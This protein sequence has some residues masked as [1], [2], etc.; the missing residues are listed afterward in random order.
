MG[1]R[2]VRIT[3]ID[4]IGRV[5]GS[6]WHIQQD[7]KG[8]LQD[9]GSDLQGEGRLLS[10]RLR[11][12]DSRGVEDLLDLGLVPRVQG[13]LRYDLV[14]NPERYEDF[15]DLDV[16]DLLLT[17]AHADHAGRLWALD[18]EIRVHC[19]SL[20]AA[21][22]RASSLCSSGLASEATHLVE[23]APHPT[24]RGILHKP[25][26]GEVL[27]RP[28]LTVDGAPSGGLRELWKAAGSEAGLGESD[29]L[30][31][32]MPFR[33]FPVDH[34]ILGTQAFAIET[35]AGMIVHAA[36]LR[37]HGG[38]G[39]LTD[40][41]VRWLDR[42][43]V[44]ALIL[45]GTRLGREDDEP[46]TEAQC[47]E[48]LRTLVREAGRRLVVA[49]YSPRN[50]ERLASFLA[51]AQ[52]AG[53]ELVVQARTMAMLEAVGAANPAFDLLSVGGL[54][55]YDPPKASRPAWHTALRERRE[56]LVVSP[57]EIKA[58]PQKYVMEH[59][60]FSTVDL[61]D[62][63]PYGALLLDSNSGAYSSEATARYRMLG[64]WARL[65]A[66]DTAGIEFKNGKALRDPRLAPSGHCHPDDLRWLLDRAKPELL[67]PVHT[68]M[69]E[70]FREFA[71]EG[72]KVVLP[73][74]GRAIRL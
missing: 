52:G 58:K 30:A 19:S 69:P 71:P 5:G 14:L 3:P 1:S 40:A 7:E 16:R 25:R 53:R 45:E 65:Y 64:E 60:F 67:V 20:T 59:G 8:F 18:P 23:R 74:N 28:I 49:S 13:L 31:A 27:S 6:T 70:A 68:T 42:N 36:D 38:S 56:G 66:M 46:V 72:T 32:G 29:M 35:D 37:R 61:L 21:L 54:R 43:D 51:A 9:I 62:L 11:P 26:G 22:L 55:L 12:R 47:L 4:G 73:E 34:S 41:F 24:E 57:E 63:Q 39:F 10:G 33:T 15:Q 44:R 2:R 48:R 50:V 17:H